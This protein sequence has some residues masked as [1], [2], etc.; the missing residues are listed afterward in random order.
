ML[1]IAAD[2]SLLHIFSFG[3]TQPIDPIHAINATI[4]SEIEQDGNWTAAVTVDPEHGKVVSLVFEI[5]TC[6]MGSSWGATIKLVDIAMPLGRKSSHAR[7]I[8]RVAR[9]CVMIAYT[10]LV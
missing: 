7:E 8:V 9:C 5:F 1:R 10:W 6:L 2:M 4:H 3:L